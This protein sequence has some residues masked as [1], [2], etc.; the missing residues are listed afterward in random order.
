MSTSNPADALPGDLAGAV[1]A[2]EEAHQERAAGQAAMAAAWS[3]LHGL[4]D[5]LAREVTTRQG[6]IRLLP[7]TVEQILAAKAQQ[8]ATNWQAAE[9]AAEAARTRLADHRSASLLT[10]LRP[11]WR[12][13][14]ARLLREA[15]ASTA[16]AEHI[17]PAAFQPDGPEYQ[18]ACHQ[19]AANRL[20]NARVLAPVMPYQARLE[21]IELSIKAV[22]AGDEAARA[23]LQRWDIPLLEQVARLWRRVGEGE[24]LSDAEQTIRRH[25]IS[26]PVAAPPEEAGPTPLEAMLLALAERISQAGSGRVVDAEWHEVP[27]PQ[28][29]VTQILLSPPAQSAS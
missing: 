1:A 21:A 15:A 25:A 2:I 27:H 17:Q 13:M 29:A 18:A 20:V 7:A 6:G 10:R 5:G 3:R 19:A 16:R 12:E 14:D 8:Q 9:T 28:R 26:P 22:R 11:S 24:F 23:C 4:R